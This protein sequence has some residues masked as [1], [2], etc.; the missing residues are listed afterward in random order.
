MTALAPSTPAERPDLRVHAAL[1]V[2]QIAFASQ[3]V[4]GKIAMAPREAGGEAISPFAVAMVRML[5]AA[6]IFQALTRGM[7][8]LRPT[9]RRDHLELAG[10]SIIG[11]ALNQT[12]FLVGLSITTPTTASL[13]S[14]TIPVFTAAI[15]VLSRKERATPRLGLGLASSLAGAVWLAG[16][17]KVD[18][19]AIVVVANSLSYSAYVVF[20]RDAIRRLGTLT[21]VTWVF[22]WGALLFAPIG[23]PALVAGAPTWTARGFG[24]IG[25]I[26]LVPTI[27]AY[28][29]NAWALGRSSATL[30]TIYIYVQPVIAGLLAWVQLGQRVEARMVGAAALIALG[31][32]LVASRGPRSFAERL[33][34]RATP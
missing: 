3:A 29:C 8:L 24:F 10:L 26:V 4:E 12:L 22:T 27:V 28:L 33:G 18:L 32:A 20:A 16:V 14:V 2:V 15:A 23:L 31:V 21:V 19:G 30:V 34:K 11:I 13:L 1:L 6:A 7:H 17:G 25:Y 9:S 5:A